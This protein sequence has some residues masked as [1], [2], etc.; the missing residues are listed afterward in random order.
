MF[1]DP[2]T[3]AVGVAVGAGIGYYATRSGPVDAAAAAAAPAAAP[4][5]TL[6]KMTAAERETYVNAHVP[7]KS[8]STTIH[9]HHISS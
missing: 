4:S 1:L 3:L 9:H 8:N 7:I 2:K 5:K 6:D